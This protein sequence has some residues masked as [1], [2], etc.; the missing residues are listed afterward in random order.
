MVH[1]VRT[2]RREIG[3]IGEEIACE[4]LARRG[5]SVVEQNYLKPWGEID[6]V[7]K[8][9]GVYH[10]VE[11]KA[12]SREKGSR[13]TFDE[14]TAE[15]HIHSA[16]MKKLIRTVELYMSHVKGSPDY[17]IDV[18]TV[19]LDHGTRRAKCKHYEQVL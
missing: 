5:F 10:F 9:G 14:M 19:E 16:K 2:R 8:K 17:Q 6:I 11:V 4:Y 7:A 18:V 15:D 1:V 13:A 12:I 3:D